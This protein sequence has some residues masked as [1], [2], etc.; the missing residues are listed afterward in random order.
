MRIQFFS[1]IHLE[2]G[3]FAVPPADAHVIVAAGDIGVG[4]A[5]VPWL[6]A[7]GRPVIYIAGNH[8]YYGADF[9]ALQA[10]LAAATRGS[11]VHYL[12][13]GRVDIDG[14]RFLGT[15]LWTDFNNADESV[16][17]QAQLSINDYLQIRH[18]ADS[19]T[20]DRALAVHRSARAWLAV[21]LAA[22]WPGRTV[23][24]THHAPTPRSWRGPADSNYRYAYCSD[25]AP[26]AA[27][28]D[29]PLWIHGHTH[30]TVDYVWDGVRVVC[31]PRGYHGLQWVDGFDPSRIIEI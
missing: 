1:D 16:M 31:N 26:L 5:A 3:S 14:V 13:N 30:W 6:T 19:F 15:T 28:A 20:P 2:F 17:R 8:E 18:G 22:P 21:E 24:V 27:G 9:G 4:L 29:V 12:E 25:L 7:L 11:N 10:Q 23:V